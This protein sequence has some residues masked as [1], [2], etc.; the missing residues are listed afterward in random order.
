MLEK[1]DGFKKKSLCYRVTSISTFWLKNK[2]HNL[3]SNLKRDPGV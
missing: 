2:T 1:E 3:S